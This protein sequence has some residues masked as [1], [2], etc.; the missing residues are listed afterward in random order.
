MSEL[1]RFPAIFYQSAGGRE[2]VRDWFQGLST[3]EK[4]SVGDDLQKLEYGWPV[5]MPL[6]KS[7]GSGIHELRSNLPKGRTA[8]VFF[9][10]E[11]RTLILV[12]AFIKKSR[13]TPD[14]DLELARRRKRD[15]ERNG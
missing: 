15:W 4:K 3:V 14:Q 13:K 2:P 1:K 5:G 8:R 12:H 6:A 7:M 10:V 9:F 11:G